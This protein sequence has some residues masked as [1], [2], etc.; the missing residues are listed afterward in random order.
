M[1]E[2]PKRLSAIDIFNLPPK[3]GDHNLVD[4][5]VL[6][7]NALKATK[8][9]NVFMSNPS[10]ANVYKLNPNSQRVI[11]NKFLLNRLLIFRT[12]SKESVTDIIT[13]LANDGITEDWI[14]LMKEFVLPFIAKNEVLTTINKSK[15]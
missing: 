7:L 14:T 5:I 4:L 3:P 13:L 8:E 11:I 1:N 2:K 12:I 9:A 6:H 15:L 10:I